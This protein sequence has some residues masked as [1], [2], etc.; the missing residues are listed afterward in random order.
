MYS[1]DFDIKKENNKYYLIREGRKIKALFEPKEF[2]CDTSKSL[3][4]FIRSDLD[5]NGKIRIRDDD[6]IEVDQFCAYFIF[7]KQK[8]LLNNSDEVIKIAPLYDLSLIQTVTSPFT[9]TEQKK[10][11]AD[12]RN[13]TKKHLGEEGFLELTKYAWG[14]IYKNMG[15]SYSES[16][17]HDEFKKTLISKKVFDLIKDLSIAKQNVIYF[18]SDY[19]FH[20]SILLSIGLVEKWVSVESFIQAATGIMGSMKTGFPHLRVESDD[21]WHRGTYSD[22]QNV[23][24]LSLNYITHSEI[25]TP[26]ELT[27]E[28]SLTHEYKSSFRTPYP[29]YPDTQVDDNGQIFYKLGTNKFKSKNEVHKFLETQCL[30]TIVAFLNTNGG[31]LVVGVQEKDN[32]K[33][34]VG[35]G[36][37]KFKS[38]EE[39]ER[40]ISQ[41]ITNRI[42][43]KFHGDFI[44]IE[45][46]PVDDISYC[47]ITCKKY[48][49]SENQIPAHLDK[50]KCFRRTGPRTD[51]IKGAEAATFAVERLNQNED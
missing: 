40:H 12:I 50:E 31:T 1:N 15:E 13:A 51:E 45:T 27:L 22:F 28:E 20:K 46:R 47:L 38:N 6:T 36:R 3:I 48:I 18:L 34:N 37:E 43:K 5:R 23:A 8:E 4:E 35:I 49:P 41:Q 14:V 33:T 30:K 42:G 21:E 39:Y 32:H 2:V 24:I 26:K 10:R 44:T 19:F 16:I 25:S 7:S 17:S 29:D 9:E 11:F